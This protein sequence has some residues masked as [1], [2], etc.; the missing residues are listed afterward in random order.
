[1]GLIFLGV[2]Y[3]LYVMNFIKFV[4]SINNTFPIHMNGTD[5]HQYFALKKLKS[6]SKLC[7]S[8]AITYSLTHS[9]THSFTHSQK[10]LKCIKRKKKWNNFFMRIKESTYYIFIDINT[11]ISSLISI[12]FKFIPIELSIKIIFILTRKQK[13]NSKVSPII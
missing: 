2:S 12:C 8:C 5:K 9:F 10:L 3:F 7:T 11:E 1:M 13:Y 6:I 4:L